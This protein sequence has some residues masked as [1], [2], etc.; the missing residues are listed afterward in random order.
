[1]THLENLED[2]KA[3]LDDALD[4]RH[5]PYITAEVKQDIVNAVNNALYGL[6]VAAMDFFY[7]EEQTMKFIE[8]FDEQVKSLVDLIEYMIVQDTLEKTNA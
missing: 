5:S 8:D 4:D 1:M 6:F 2:S 7:W 3:M